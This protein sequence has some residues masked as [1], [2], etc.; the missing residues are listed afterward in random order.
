MYSHFFLN[1]PF[2]LKQYWNTCI[3][4]TK[5]LSL[6]CRTPQQSASKFLPFLSQLASLGSFIHT[7]SQHVLMEGRLFSL[8]LLCTF[9]F[10]Y[11]QSISYDYIQK[12]FHFQLLSLPDIKCYW[13]YN[14]GSAVMLIWSSHFRTMILFLKLHSFYILLMLSQTCVKSCLKSSYKKTQ[15]LSLFPAPKLVFHQVSILYWLIL[16]SDNPN[17]KGMQWEHSAWRQRMSQER[18]SCITFCNTQAETWNEGQALISLLWWQ[19]TGPE[20]TARSCVKRGLAWILEKH[21]SPRVGFP[22]KWS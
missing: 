17:K 4:F 2:W 13:N 22:G 3:C 18:S 12:T 15:K 21:S 9:T 8:K 10:N 19:V 11:F 20:R 1:V 16:W 14:F 7:V 5:N 6:N